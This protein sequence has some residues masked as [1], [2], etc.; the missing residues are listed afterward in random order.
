M[1]AKASWFQCGFSWRTST[2]EGAATPP[3]SAAAVDNFD[4][5]RARGGNPYRVCQYGREVA[6]S[7]FRQVMDKD[8]DKGKF[9]AISAQRL[10]CHCR[11][12]QRP[13]TGT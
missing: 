13:V 7:I 6:I 4:C 2:R 3:T 9:K 8:N 12:E 10:A 11:P 5:S 1:T